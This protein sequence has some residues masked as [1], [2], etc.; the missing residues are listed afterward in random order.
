[1]KSTDTLSTVFA[2][3]VVVMSA[4]VVPRVLH[5]DAVDRDGMGAQALA[6]AGI[7]GFDSSPFAATRMASAAWRSAGSWSVSVRS[8]FSHGR[9]SLGARPA[10]VDISQQVLGAEVLRPWIRDWRP[11]P[12]ARLQ[13]RSAEQSPSI[14][15][16][17]AF[18]GAWELSEHLRIVMNASLPMT[19]LQ[20]QRSH[21]LDER[22]QIFSNSLQWTWLDE[23]QQRMDMQSALLA[24]LP[25]GVILSAGLWLGQRVRSEAEVYIT[26]LSG[27]EI[28]PTNIETEVLATLAPT[29]SLTWRATDNWTVHAGWQGARDSGVET[30]SRVKIRGLD[31]DANSQKEDITRLS[32]GQVAA[33]ADIEI[34]WSQGGSGVAIGAT[35]H[36]TST[37]STLHSE[38][39]N[40]GLNDSWTARLAGSVKLNRAWS[41]LGGLSWRQSPLPEQTGRQNL[42]DNDL[43][44]AAVG[45]TWTHRSS[46]AKIQVS[47]AW[48]STYAIARTHTKRADAA[49]PV[50]DEFPDSVD[51]KTTEAIE[52][53]HG[54][55]TNN[56]GFPYYRSEAWMHVANLT[57]AVKR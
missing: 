8:G 25:G 9:L 44:S 56:P 11:L 38:Q 47:L 36:S 5:A 16:L 15:N 40:G 43:A 7:V 12:T 3:I 26:S 51:P 17:V 20:G 1:M 2:A 24:K 21:F 10:S 52:S 41:V 18:G 53:S 35:L 30:I 29:F 37:L 57:L 39:V 27:E 34:G 54:F 48:K 19:R 31:G 14:S 4:S 55:Q 42:V 23:S 22:E 46:W 45:A 49:D 28:S 6:L 33:R 13:P 50:F 32:L